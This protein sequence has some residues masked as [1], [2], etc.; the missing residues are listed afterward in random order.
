MTA[1]RPPAN[2]SALLHNSRGEYLLHLR[3]DIPGIREPGAWSLPGG[4]REPGDRD[5]EDTVR[6]ELR[7]EAA[8]E[9]GP[10]E[11]FAVVHTTDDD[12]SALPVQIFTGQWD[13]DPGALPLTEGVMLRWFAPEILP[14]L[15]MSPVTRDVIRRHTAPTAPAPDGAARPDTPRTITSAPRTGRPPVPHATL[16]VG[17]ILHGP[18]GVLLGRHRRGT[19]ELPGGA[20]EPGEPLTRTV[21]RKLAE[22]TGL[23]AHEDG[24]QLLGLLL[25]TAAGTTRATVAALVTSWDGEPADQ[26]G[27]TVGDWRW[28]RPDALPDGLFVPSAQCLTL[29]RPGLPIGHPPAHRYPLRPG[30]GR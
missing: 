3:D 16:G 9:P 7:E 23:T 20:V 27:E 4:G 13:G 19:V 25:D 29:W 15:R 21:V 6:R 2:A 30:R 10:L 1:D 17:I 24:V 14:R 8:L 26:P 28:H 12:G 22:E 5:L 11:P 18:D